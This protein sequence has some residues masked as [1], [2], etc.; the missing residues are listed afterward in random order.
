MEETEPT[1]GIA[2]LVFKATWETLALSK[3]M[4]ANK[5]SAGKARAGGGA[6][7]D[8]RRAAAASQA[9]AAQSASCS[10]GPTHQIDRTRTTHA[11]AVGVPSRAISKYRNNNY[12]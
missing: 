12:I 11:R 3:H 9:P 6:V 7:R 8:D 2:Y 10:K 5:S 1:N 4:A